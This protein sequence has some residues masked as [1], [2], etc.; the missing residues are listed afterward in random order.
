MT[1]LGRDRFE[2]T[3]AESEIENT[4][5]T[6]IYIYVDSRRINRTSPGRE[7]G[8]VI[9]TGTGITGTDLRTDFWRAFIFLALAR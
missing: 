7:S 8:R 5:N 4:F 1:R 2:E 6:E 9:A 3:L